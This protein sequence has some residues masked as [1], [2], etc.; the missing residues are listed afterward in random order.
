MNTEVNKSNVLFL[1]VF[2]VMQYVLLNCPWDT[3][4]TYDT[5]VTVQNFQK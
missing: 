1:G 3:Y 5:S 2:F 4:D